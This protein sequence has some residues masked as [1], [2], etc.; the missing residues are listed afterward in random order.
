[1]YND[2]YFSVSQTF[3]LVTYSLIAQNHC[4]NMMDLDRHFLVSEYQISL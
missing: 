2:D 1:M 3:T 4:K